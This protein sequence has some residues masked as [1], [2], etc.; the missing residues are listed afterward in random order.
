MN[1]QDK[2]QMYLESLNT[3]VETERLRREKV[4]NTFLR[5]SGF[6]SPDVENIVKFQLDSER[7]LNKCYHILSGHKIIK[8]SDGNEVWQDPED[9]RL[10]IFSKFGVDRI[11]QLLQMHI[12][13]EVTLSIFDME[14]INREVRK[15]AI[16]LTDLISNKYEF[17]F[18]YPS[19]EELYENILPHKP[20]DITDLELYQKCIEWSNDELRMKLA[21]YPVIVN[22]LTSLVFANYSRALKGET[23]KSLRTIT[24]ISQSI[25]SS[26][27]PMTQ[28]KKRGIFPWSK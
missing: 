6:N 13:P 11:M 21:N 5:D 19:P 25:N 2:L 26:L 23:L 15:F 20:I 12:T 18:H 27:D 28:Q 17:F 9:D 4:E 16:E 22:S 8:D 3:A 7:L 24:H 14:T 10:K 1:E